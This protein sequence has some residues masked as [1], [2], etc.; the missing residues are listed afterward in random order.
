[1]AMQFR[2]D[3]LK[4]SYKLLA[5]QAVGIKPVPQKTYWVDTFFNKK[6]GLTVCTAKAYRMHI[7]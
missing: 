6:T 4:I 1:M 5:K 3:A 2:A 7:V